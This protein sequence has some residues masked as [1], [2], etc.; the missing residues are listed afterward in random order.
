MFAFPL[1]RGSRRFGAVELYAEIGGP[2]TAA[3]RADAQTLVEVATAYLLNA[4]GLADLRS[5]SDRSREA[6][7]HDPLTG[8]PNRILMLDRMEHAFRRSRRTGKKSAAL[9]V[10]LDRLKEVNDVHGHRTGDQLIAAVAER[11][12][13]TIRPGDTAARMSGDEFVILCEELDAPADAAAIGARLLLAIGEPFVLS[14]SVVHVTASIG[15]AY[16]DHGDHTPEQLLQEADSA[17][18]QA[19]RAGG[20]RHLIYD[21]HLRRALQAQTALETDLRSAVDQGD[22][23]NDYQ[24]IV[25]SKDGQIA[26]LEVFLRWRHSV[27]GLVSPRA[28][29]AM[30]EQSSAAALIGRGTMDR[31]CADRD[32][33]AGGRMDGGPAVS[34]N[35]PARHLTAPDF[36]ETVAA[37]LAR[38]AGP[39]RKLVLQITE[40][41]L[42]RDAERSMRALTALHAV[43]VTL[44][45]DGFGAGSSSLAHLRR[46]PFDVVKLD[47]SLLAGPSKGT[48]NLP[49]ARAVTRLAH[50]LGMTVIADGV[51][52]REQHRDG[53]R[54][55]LR[56]RPGRVLRPADDRSPGRRLDVPR[57]APGGP[58][59]GGRAAP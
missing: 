31:A 39:A 40:T 52:T 32:R 58:R 56:G 33:W 14:G 16:A 37:V 5:V 28:L 24:A 19:K 4:H 57:Q 26:A 13:Q 44:A 55:G 41:A 36:P 53:A 54:A 9:F 18:Y 30:T 20:N 48:S 45:L 11:M 6:A 23:Y 21:V 12:S 8:L 42:L 2:L 43:G 1:R 35:V 15:I 7:L 38:S 46:Y 51:D 49:V 25:G 29:L 22:L 17:M 59:A 50:D 47:R 10:D 27:H 3:A 34:V